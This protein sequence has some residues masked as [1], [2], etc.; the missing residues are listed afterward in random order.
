MAHIAELTY[1]SFSF[2]KKQAS[3]VQSNQSLSSSFDSS[4]SQDTLIIEERSS[5]K[6]MRLDDGAKRWAI[7][8]YL[9]I[10]GTVKLINLL[11]NT[12][13]I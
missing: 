10:W 5:S 3:P 2:F 12:T 1:L 9:C 6:G 13:L 11:K 7:S 8:Y 4:D